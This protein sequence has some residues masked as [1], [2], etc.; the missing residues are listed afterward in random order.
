MALLEIEILG[1]KVFREEAAPVEG[2]THETRRLIRDMFD[3]M[4][5]AEGIGLAGPQVGV[6]QRVL[7]VDVT[8]EDESRHEHALINPVI[9]ESSK[10]TDK[11]V[12][13]C[14]SIPG[15]EEKVTRPVRVTV[16]ALSPDGEPVRIEADDLLARALQ[17]E[18]DHL[19]GVLF[20][21]RLSPLKRGMVLKKWR[22]ARAANPGRVAGSP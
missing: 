22:K 15:I 21:D 3:T 5:H 9:V 11:A 20:L 14:L 19:N 12:E 17:H 7:V 4:Y 10:A 16:E 2:V 8:N 1:S 13:G 18:V 6:S